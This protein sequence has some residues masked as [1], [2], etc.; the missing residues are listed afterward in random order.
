[1]TCVRLLEILPVLFEKICS[2]SNYVSS[3]PRMRSDYFSNY[4]WLYDLMDWGR[5][6]LVVIARYWKQTIVSL[7]G[8]LKQHCNENSTRVIRTI[9]ELLSRGE[10]SWF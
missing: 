6:S 5:S 4:K 7:L 1:M 10:F 9:E 2:L 3:N 8:I